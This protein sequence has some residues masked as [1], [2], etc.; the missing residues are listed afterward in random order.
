NCLRP[1]LAAVGRVGVVDVLFAAF[2]GGG[3]VLR[4]RVVE[5]AAA[6]DGHLREDVAGPVGAAVGDLD[7]VPGVAA[8]RRDRDVVP[9][10]WAAAEGA[11]ADERDVD[12]VRGS[13]PPGVGLLVHDRRPG[14]VDVHVVRI[15]ARGLG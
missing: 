10:R 1:V 12:P 15:G 11:G 7:A 2:T 13:R 6:V 3:G 8:V 14:G 5:I 4:P 9:P